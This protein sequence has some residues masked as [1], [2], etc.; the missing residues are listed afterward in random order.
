MPLQEDKDDLRQD[1][2]DE[3]YDLEREKIVERQQ[4]ESHEFKMRSDDDLDYRLDYLDMLS[5]IREALDTL[6]VNAEQYDLDFK[7]TVQFYIEEM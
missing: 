5:D 3:S 2:L 6:R 7:D 4:E 1:M